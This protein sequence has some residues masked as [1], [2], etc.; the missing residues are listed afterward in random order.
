MLRNRQ[1]FFLIIILLF[2]LSSLPTTAL[3]TDLYDFANLTEADAVA[4][5]VQNN[6]SIPE[7]F[8]QLEDF[9]DFTRRLILQAY[10]NPND[11]FCFN[12]DVTQKYA[13]EI[14][15]SV[16]LYTN[17]ESVPA[18]ATATSYSLL[19]NKVM[20]ENGHWVTSGGYY[21]EKWRH[22]NC[23]AYSINRAEQPG[24]YITGKQYQPGDMSGVGTFNSCDT[25]NELAEI[26][27]ADIEAMG[28]SS[29]LVSPT[30]PSVN[31]SQ[32]LI[33]VRRLS[34]YDYH[35]MRYDIDTN[36][37][38]HKPGETSVLKYN[39]VP[40]N[41]LLWY[42]EY[43][44]DKGEH[45]STFA[46]DSDIVFIRYDKNQ[47]NVNAYATSRENI[48]KGKDVFC[49]LNFANSGNCEFSLVS[50]YSIR[51]EIYDENFDII[52]YGNGTDNDF[53]INMNAGKYYLRINIDVYHSYSQYVDISIHMPSYT[54]HYDQ[55]SST[56]HKAYCECGE[57][58]IQDHN[59]VDYEKTSDTC[60]T[61]ICVCGYELEN[62]EHFAYRYSY[63]VM[64]NDNHKVYCA[65]G[66]L[67]REEYHNC[68]TVLDTTRCTLCGYVRKPGG[69]V[70]M[71]KKDEEQII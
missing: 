53:L 50:T 37:W 24:F 19:H 23:Y 62:Q 70:I 12:Y 65:C 61:E 59:Y 38:Y 32:Q 52:C 17:L 67:L 8:L 71:G 31:S 10:N 64:D 36:S 68:V 51:Y 44:D 21:N 63:T 6:I 26:V 46:Y 4:F 48:Q 45:P 9:P 11:A 43:S 2:G 20:D 42:S 69:N 56:Q 13:E 15:T 27:R 66:H 49:E 7:E 54:H 5:V 60:H 18:I 28:Y 29:I 25:I 40:S 47:I 34:N 35:F 14:R 39:Y 55:L 30:I 58:I 41:N 57:Y 1:R 22:Y 16:I 3:E 33:C